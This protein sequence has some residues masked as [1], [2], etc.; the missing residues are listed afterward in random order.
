MTICD[1]F[2][3]FSFRGELLSEHGYMMCSF[4]DVSTAS[5][6]STD[7]QRA[8][9]SISMHHGKYQPIVVA[10]YDA[11][12]TFE[13]DIC[14]MTTDE[15]IYVT[16]S[17]AAE[18]KRWLLSPA[19][20]EFYVIGDKYA[21]YYWSGSFNVSEVHADSMCV[22]FHLT[23]TCDAPF[24]YK[25]L[26]TFS[27]SVGINGV[28]TIEDT[29]D[30]EGYIYPTITITPSEA[31]TLT[32]VNNF[33]GAETIIKNCLNSE[34]IK[35]SGGTLQLSSSAISHAIHDDFNYVF[36]RINNKYGS[37]TNV[38]TFSL[39]CSYSISYRPIAKVVIS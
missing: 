33:D 30:E 15:T 32:I 14:K 36:P 7:S 11:A 18:L 6:V 16:P 12:L 28:V 13:L 25:D 29:S 23:F 17:E 20:Q 8:F 3:D 26:R 31:G 39:P 22:G 2:E 37:T 27:G 19:S 24:G 10:L 35:F 4:T 9:S 38:F 21:G 1:L 34:T 5:S